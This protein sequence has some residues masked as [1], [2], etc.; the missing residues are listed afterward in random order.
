MTHAVLPYEP[1]LTF[2][3]PVYN[4]AP[5]LDECIS[6]IL[7]AGV[8]ELEVL[9]VDDGSTD[10]SG[11]MCDAWQ[12]REPHIRVIHQ[13]NAG[14][15]VARNVALSEAKGKYFTFVDA[16]DWLAPEI[17][18]RGLAYMQAHPEVGVLEF[19]YAE[20]RGLEE[21]VF[22]ILG[23]EETN[24]AEKVL[25]LF[26]RMK[27]PI[28][29]PWAKIFRTELAGDLRFPEG[30]IYED[31]PFVFSALTRSGYYHYMA[32]VGY[33]YRIGRRGSST[34]YW[35]EKLVYLFENLLDLQPD[36]RQTSPK[37]LPYLYQALLERLMV[38]TLWAERNRAAC[39]R[40]LP[41]LLPYTKALRG[42]PLLPSSFAG[43]VRAVLFIYTPSLF[44]RLKR[45][46]PK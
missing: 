33:Y 25:E 19:G 44:L 17:L 15:S 5:W 40:L 23:Q 9:L 2:I 16:D 4:V 28:G 3:V 34:E 38:F 31:T 39:P 41:L 22:P 35:D 45:I 42:K 43:K 12:A 29:M 14:Q 10:G 30:R 20:V 6:S 36:L 7:R 27:G 8:S 18:G 37:L 32:E 11:A 26:A 13:P 24:N 21:E 46:F 1:L